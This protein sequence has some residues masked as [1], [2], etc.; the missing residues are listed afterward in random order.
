LRKLERK[1]LIYTHFLLF[2]TSIADILQ[3][4]IGSTRK[5]RYYL[6]YHARSLQIMLKL[7]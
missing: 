1:N 5:I 4:Y 6:V 7:V 2:P 3:Y